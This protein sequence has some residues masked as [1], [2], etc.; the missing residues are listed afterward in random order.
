MRFLE[1]WQELFW[2]VGTI[3]VA[4]G[5]WYAIHWFD[6]RVGADAGEM[7]SIATLMIR[8]FAVMFLA[9]FTKHLYFIDLSDNVDCSLHTPPLTNDKV[10]LVIKDRA[11]WVFLLVFWA[12]LFF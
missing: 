11:E 4:F 5:L 2:L 1:K 3:A 9:W 7:Y 10:F 12:W 8:A 6:A